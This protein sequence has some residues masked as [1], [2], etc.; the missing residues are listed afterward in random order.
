MNADKL[1]EK[2]RKAEAE[3][4]A[5]K[6]GKF[7]PAASWVRDLA[8]QVA[9]ECKEGARVDAVLRALKDAHAEAL[10]CEDH[11]EPAPAPKEEPKNWGLLADPEDKG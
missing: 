9:G 1:L 10:L 6:R 5:S 2:M 4:L 7:H 8:E 11:G 3:A